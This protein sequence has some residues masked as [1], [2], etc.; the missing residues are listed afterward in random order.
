MELF[1]G[2][3]NQHIRI[4]E[5][6]AERSTR[7]VLTTSFIHGKR[8]AEACAAS[9]PSTPAGRRRCGASSSAATW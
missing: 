2:L 4:A 8:F 7:G 3:C 9:E 5:V 1:R 6:I